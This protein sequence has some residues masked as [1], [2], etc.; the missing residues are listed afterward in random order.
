[1]K[2]ADDGVDEEVVAVVSL[3]CSE[4]CAAELVIAPHTKAESAIAT[5]A[6]MI[7][8]FIAVKFMSRKVFCDC[9]IECK[10]NAKS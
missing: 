6:V 5:A 1:M 4:A 2:R 9:R 3:D 7:V 8:F 10:Y